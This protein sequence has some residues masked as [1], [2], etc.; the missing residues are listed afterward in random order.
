ML[1]L[2]LERLLFLANKFSQKN[3][4]LKTSFLKFLFV[5][6]S[7]LFFSTALVGCATT[8]SVNVVDASP[9][10]IL[11]K[12]NIGVMK[13]TLYPA[14]APKAVAELLKLIE[15]GYYDTDTVLESRSG[16]GLVIAK[17][18]PSASVF[19]FEDETSGLKSK[20]GSLAINK[21]NVSNAY[22]NNLFVGYNS[23]P[24]LEQHYT[25]IGQ[26]TEGLDAIE[27]SA[28]GARYAIKSIE[29]L[30]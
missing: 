27:S 7:P 4:S 20:R 2:R 19:K 3:A 1:W 25:I 6:L 26:A 28:H 10:N 16:L 13:V 5:L 23:Q 29:L 11:I 18:G 15:S 21:S 14:R 30:K 17:T 22:L 8:D 12:V 24:S 9:V